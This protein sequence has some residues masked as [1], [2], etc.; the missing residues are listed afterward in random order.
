MTVTMVALLCS[1][2]VLFMYFAY[3]DSWMTGQLNELQKEVDNLKAS[4]SSDEESTGKI[5]SCM[6]KFSIP[7]FTERLH[8]IFC[9][10]DVCD[11][12]W[13]DILVEEGYFL[14]IIW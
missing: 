3:R 8:G 11:L 6:F 5:I 13:V 12:V 2:I 7:Y 9:T 4:T 1:S 10:K 14:Y